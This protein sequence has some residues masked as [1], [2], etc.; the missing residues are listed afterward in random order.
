MTVSVPK[1]GAPVLSIIPKDPEMM[2]SSIFRRK[3][4]GGDRSQSQSRKT[5]RCLFGPPDANV[6]IQQ[7]N[8]VQNRMQQAF[9]NRWGFNCTTGEPVP[10]VN[11]IVGVS[12][13]EE[14]VNG[15]NITK[16]PRYEWIKVS[17]DEDEVHQKKIT[18]ANNNNNNERLYPVNVSA[19]SV[20]TETSSLVTQGTQTYLSNNED[21]FKNNNHN[22]LGDYNLY[23]VARK[24]KSPASMPIPII[25]KKERSGGN[26]PRSLTIMPPCSPDESD[27][28]ILY[29]CIQSSSLE[30]MTGEELMESHL[31]STQQE[32]LDHHHD[33]NHMPSPI[34]FSP[35]DP[36]D[37][38]H[39]E[40]SPPPMVRRNSTGVFV[41]PDST[42]VEF[43]SLHIRT[44]K[45]G[46]PAARCYSADSKRMK[47]RCITGKCTK[48]LFFSL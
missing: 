22:S 14:G 43:Q 31:D 44:N 6:V 36:I 42:A 17:S 27:D 41:F 35:L 33:D 39:H 16:L 48:E 10:V 7:A 34:L 45:N 24:R 30:S 9:E 15:N 21:N 3:L 5:S 46:S 2:V 26:F 18:E 12:P 32:G 20:Q 29:N 37:H 38:R 13:K 23:L 40:T 8:E 28:N 4:V 19:A 1:V 47:Q 25:M 11:D